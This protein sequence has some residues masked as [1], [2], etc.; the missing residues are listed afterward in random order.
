MGGRCAQGEYLLL[1][2]FLPLKN[3]IGIQG[4]RRSGQ[5]STDRKPRPRWAVPAPGLRAQSQV[6]ELA[7]GTRRPLQPNEK[8]RSRLSRCPQGDWVGGS[9]VYSA[10][11]YTEPEGA[12]QLLLPK[13]TQLGSG[14]LRIGVEKTL[15]NLSE[16][17][18]FL[19][20]QL[21]N[22]TPVE[23]A[24]DLVCWN[25]ARD[26]PVN[27]RVCGRN[28]CCPPKGEQSLPAPKGDRTA[29]LGSVALIWFTCVSVATICAGP[30][31]GGP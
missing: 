6:C 17:Q 7:S 25:L 22:P 26:C 27:V 9:A 1:S 23:R 31:L 24:S 2:Q 19:C 21:E 18:F 5:L 16:P 20:K 4:L 29:T 8:S 12:R 13:V 10:D 30:L 15:P 14:R 11:A 3:G 28:W